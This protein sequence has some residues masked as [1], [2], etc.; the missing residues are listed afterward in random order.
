MA[1]PRSFGS[2]QVTLRPPI[3][4]CPVSTSS[5]P[6]MAL[7]SVDLPQPEG[8]S[9]T[10]SS[11]SSTSSAKRSK[12][13]TAPKAIVTSRTETAPIGSALHGT[14]GDAAHEPAP[15]KEVDEER[16]QRGQ[17]GR[18]HVDVVV[19]LA[20]GRVDDVV[21]LHGHRQVLAA[22]EGQAED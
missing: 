17:H 3:Q 5:R 4:I 1:M 21:E 6:A 9:R 14:S 11:P 22:G 18:R 7:R 20:L 10:R 15:G 8:P 2:S 12:T 19:P 13:R 16:D